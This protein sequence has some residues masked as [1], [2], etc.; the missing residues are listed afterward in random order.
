MSLQGFEGY[1]GCRL[2]YGNHLGYGRL[3]LEELAVEDG[4]VPMVVKVCWSLNVSEGSS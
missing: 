4:S 1:A 2:H 3:Q